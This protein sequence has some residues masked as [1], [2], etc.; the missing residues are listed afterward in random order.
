M[1]KVYLAFCVYA[2]NPY[3]DPAKIAKDPKYAQLFDATLEFGRKMNACFGRISRTVACTGSHIEAFVTHA[4]VAAVRKV[5][6]PHAEIAN[7]TYSHSPIMRIRGLDGL[8]PRS[9]LS[10]TEITEELKKTNAI[11]AEVFK[12]RTFGFSAPCGHPVPLTPKVAQAIKSAGC[13]YS[14]SHT[15]GPGGS[16]FTPLRSEGKL[17]QPFRYQNGLPEVP[18]TG[19][20]DVFNF[21]EWFRLLHRL[22]FEKSYPKTEREILAWWTEFLD[23]AVATSEDRDIALTHMLHPAYMAGIPFIDRWG[24]RHA[25]A[26]Y[27]PALRVLAG[28]LDLAKERD[29]QIVTVGTLAK[30]SDRQ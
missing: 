2:E 24:F 4:D 12:Q 8:Y 14:H 29:V 26:G 20:Q 13:I 22:R 7:H 30:F 17:V 9:I 6:A 10:P 15:R 11:L 16:F 27:D 25:P 1:G 5:Y 3:G 23:E 18:L 21:P 28:A 19:W